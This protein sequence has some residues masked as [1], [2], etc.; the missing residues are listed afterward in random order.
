[1][2]SST[3]FYNQT[4]KKAVAVFGTVF[5]GISI[6]KP[7]KGP[8]R[9]PIAYGPAQKFITRL[10][11]AGSDTDRIQLKVPRM[12]FEISSFE[13][14]SER[15]LN[16]MNKH[17]YQTGEGSLNHSKAVF[18]GVPYN[19]G[20]T[21][22]VIAKDQDSALQIVEQI[23]P[24]FRPEYTVT[25][26]DMERP[27]LASDVPIILN[28]VTQEDSYEGTYEDSRI[29]TYTLEFNMK[30]RYYAGQNDASGIIRTI[31]TNFYSDTSP[32]TELKTELPGGEENIRITVATGDV[33][34]LDSTDTITTTFGFGTQTLAGQ[35]TANISRLVGS[36]AASTTTQDIYTEA[37]YNSNLNFVRNTSFW[38]K[39]I[40]GLTAISPWNSRDNNKRAGVAI[41][42]RH[43]LF[44][45]H[46]NFNLTVGDTIYFVTSDNTV[47][48]RTISA[49]VDTSASVGGDFNL[50]V[51]NSDL[52]D[53]VEVLR[54]FASDVTNYMSFDKEFLAFSTDQEEKGLIKK[55]I[56]VSTSAQISFNIATGYADWF[57]SAITGDSGNPSF[58]VIDDEAI[59]VT[60]TTGPLGGDGTFISDSRMISEVN[61][62][63]ATVDAAASISTG[64]TL[65]QLAIDPNKY[66]KYTY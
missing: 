28:S 57:E 34:P 56:G 45:K 41:T 6:T 54:V 59:L 35:S 48:S 49:E 32:R 5:N 25:I 36:L 19:I 40:K 46:S 51:L 21:L 30:I 2:F 55:V 62:M 38:G 11:D 65:T 47:V 53:T 52:P 8:E 43:V 37:S 27:G 4:T 9:V 20:F 17:V 31:D 12:A 50:A 60:V 66:Y 44:C 39:N 18:Q 13:L 26:K 10:N 33:P 42:K 58:I 1:M 7:N 64:Y 29:L 16:K 61:T 15:Q 63:I 22:S 24:T 14:D 3:P 23:L